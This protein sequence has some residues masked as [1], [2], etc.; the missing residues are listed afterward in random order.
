MMI[1]IFKIFLINIIFLIEKLFVRRRNRDSEI[2]VEVRKCVKPVFTS[3]FIQKWY[4]KDFDN[5][6]WIDEMR[7]L[8]DVGIDEI[9]IQSV[10]DTKEKYAFYPTKIDGYTFSEN[11]MVMMALNAAIEVNMKVRVGLAESDDWWY[12][13]WYDF[14]WL[15]H[16]IETN[17]KIIK[18]IYDNYSDHDAFGGWYIPYEFSEFFATTKLQQYN[19][20]FFYKNIADEIKNRNSDTNI[21]IAPFYYS[22]KYKIGCMKR[23]R[24]IVENV[25][26]NTNIDI[27]ALQDS[28][29]AG[30]NKI[31]DLGSLFFYTKQATDSLGMKLYADTE[32]FTATKNQNISAPNDNII[33]QIT[34]EIEYVEGFISFSINHYQNKNIES[35]SENYNNYLNYYNENK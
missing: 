9:I 27:V 33:K 2:L 26:E 4:A 17:K 10:V 13:G 11:D 24:K 1:I 19:L 14:Q 29:G 34:E 22:N 8:K 32:T 23:W 25:L 20:N 7:M 31:N 6:R 15:S 12:R 16:E 35:Q 3:S 5:K 28:V 21:L 30:F 18:E